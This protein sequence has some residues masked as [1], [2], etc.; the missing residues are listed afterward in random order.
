MATPI[1]QVITQYCENYVDDIRLAELREADPA[2]YLRQCWFFLRVAIST[3]VHPAEIQTYFW[4]TLDEPKLTEPFFAETT[5]TLDTD[6][7]GPFEIA[8]GDEYKGFELASC[9]M[10]E[11]ASD[12]YVSYYAADFAYDAQTGN[13]TIQGDYPEGTVF[14]FDFA[15][16]GEFLNTMTPEIMDILGTGFGLA[17]RERFNADWLSLVAKV[18]DKSFKEQTRSSDKRANTEQIEKMRISYAGK[19]RKFE[20]SL[21]YKKYVPDGVKINIT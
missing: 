9:R 16:D 20:Q 15:N 7:T 1:L 12:G 11:T 13:V 17:W 5:V 14:D 4:G 21:Y 6:Q 10:R 19:M 3:F 18:E 8:L 2:L